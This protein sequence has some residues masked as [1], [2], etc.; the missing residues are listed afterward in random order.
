LEAGP[1]AVAKA[2]HRVG[3]PFPAIGFHREQIDPAEAG[4]GAVPQ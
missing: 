3:G 1:A 4:G 2:E